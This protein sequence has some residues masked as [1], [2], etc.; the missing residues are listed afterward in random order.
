MSACLWLDAEQRSGRVQAV[1]WAS[2]LL[3][4]EPERGEREAAGLVLALARET[5]CRE[6]MKGEEREWGVGT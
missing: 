4:G 3:P 6:G 2:W 5:N 1:P